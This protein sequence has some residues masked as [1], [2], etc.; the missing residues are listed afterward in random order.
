MK[1]AGQKS[2]GEKLGAITDIIKNA[3]FLILSAIVLVILGVALLSGDGKS[4]VQNLY[5]NITGKKYQT[6]TP[7]QDLTK[8][9]Y[10]ILTAKLS[11]DTTIEIENAHISIFEESDISHK[12]RVEY[13]DKVYFYHVKK[14]QDGT[15]QIKQE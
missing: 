5:E 3:K 8:E 2:I 11:R 9:T 13:K 15:W 10:L 14:K 12:Y 7:V 6:F 4:V 1:K